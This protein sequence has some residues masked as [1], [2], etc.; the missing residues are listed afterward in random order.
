M[1]SPLI[2]A[3]LPLLAHDLYVMPAKFHVASPGTL[4]I[5][6]HN[7]DDFPSSQ[8]AARLE[9]L[10]EPRLVSATG[11]TPLT[12]LRVDGK[13]T[14]ADA[15]V[16]GTGT[17]IVAINTRPNRIELKAPQ[18]LSYLEHEGLLNVIESRRK[19]HTEGQPGSERYSKYVKSL[20]VA[21]APSD[22]YRH[23][24]GFPIEIIPQADPEGTHSGGTLPIQVLFRGKP[25]ADLQVEMAWLAPNG[26]ATKKV[27]GRTDRDGR[28]TIPIAGTGTWKLH[29]VLMERCADP[30]FDWESFW[31]SLTFEIR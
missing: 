3:A 15:P 1:L 16:N 8:A 27:A 19:N 13:L 9:R 14:R 31:A 25:A 22:F 7:G 10:L 11:T 12:N 28:L 18:F 6:L 24:V 26:A 29:T 30:A 4:S 5:A 2:L 17:M 20:I 23:A 21:G